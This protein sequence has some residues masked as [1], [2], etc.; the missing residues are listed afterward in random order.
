MELYNDDCFNIFP[1]IESKSINLFL[2]DLPYANKKFGNCTA[3]AWDT[4]IDLEKMWVEIKRTMKPNALIVFFC[5]TKFGYALINSNPKWFKYDL[6]W[7]KSKKVGFLS[8]NKMPL[9]KHEN[10]YIFK[11]EL[12]TYNPQKVEGKPYIDKRNHKINNYYRED[13]KPYEYTAQDN[14]GLYHPSS[15]LPQFEEEH[16]NVYIFKK[17]QGTY[18]PQ[19]S[20]G[21]KP[22]KDD[23][24][25]KPKM[26]G[27]Y[28]DDM[29]A[30]PVVNNGERHPTSILKYNNV[31]KTIHRTQKPVDLL[32]YL[33]KTYSNEEDTVMDFCMGSG[34]CGEACFNTN[35][36]F[37]GIEKDKEIFELAKNRLE[38]LK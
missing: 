37:I 13:G 27:V 38:A 14:K 4:P 5:N 25:K 12:G 17:E 11:N 33:I 19:K 6:I 28:G 26:C 30:N 24:R 29:E 3:C 20:T 34:S 7:E 31:W 10:I 21:N 36:K 15:I 23:V 32:E 9:R 22:Y 8:A 16:E 1:N 35:R 18:N 2:L